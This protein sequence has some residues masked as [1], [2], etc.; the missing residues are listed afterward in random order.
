MARR[1]DHF[2]GALGIA[3]V[4]VAAAAIGRALVRRRHKIH[5][6][7][8]VAIVTGGS[9]GLGFLIAQELG[10]RGASVAIC[11]RT[12]EAV[13]EA[14]Q[15]LRHQGVKVI[16]RA[17]DLGDRAQASAFVEHVALTWGRIDV[18]VNNAGVIHVEPAQS[19][20]L[21][22]LEQAMRS[23][24][25]SA[26]NTTFAALPFLMEQPGL[27]RIANVASIGGRVAVPHLLGYSASKFA[28]LGLSE[29]LGAELDRSG[30]RVTTIVPWL[31]RT[32]S[33][34]N[35]EFAGK[36]ERE[37]AWF[38][39][40]MLPGVSVDARRA[41]RRIVAAIQHGDPLLHVGVASAVAARLK[42]VAPG[43]FGRLMRVMNRALPAPD[44]HPEPARRGRDIDTPLHVADGA[45]RRNNEEP[46]ARAEPLRSGAPAR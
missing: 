38:S 17:C 10:R 5:F 20:T 39:L 28:L 15:K 4:G 29:G 22:G 27:A 43:L 33:H 9:R 45:A 25:W 8:R 21:D 35:A 12:L 11:G 6:A 7:G 23:N 42:G 31:M 14:E 18:L 1:P 19:V 37:L 13:D 36:P 2:L 34:Q 40:G 41:A 32:G 16:A 3:A 46:R 44:D 30:V 24:F 26:A